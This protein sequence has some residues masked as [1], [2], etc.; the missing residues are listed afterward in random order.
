ML[1]RCHTQAG[2]SVS[3]LYPD[4]SGCGL[5]LAAEMHRSDG[6]RV[7]AVG[8][9]LPTRESDHS[10][11]DT[12][13]RH[14]DESSLRPGAL[15]TK[16]RQYLASIPEGRQFPTAEALFWYMI[17]LLTRNSEWESILMYDFNRTWPAATSG[18]APF[19]FQ[20][21]AAD[22]GL[23]NPTA[24]ALWSRGNPYKTTCRHGLVRNGLDHVLSTFPSE[25]LTG[26]GIL[27]DH[28]WIS[29]SDHAP[30]W[31]G[32]RLQLRHR[33]IKAV[34]ERVER[35]LR[36][37]VDKRKVLVIQELQGKTLE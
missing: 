4:P 18:V 17:G 19:F 7:R 30:I 37:G 3:K 25:Y 23:S 11:S 5:Y 28:T 36:V 9:Y 32:Y 34:W 16:I 10:F 15:A 27:S 31:A 2:W 22:L 13:G 35:R 29:G 24:P 6:R 20:K 26:A 8:V 12:L 1:V 21:A 33:P 14:E